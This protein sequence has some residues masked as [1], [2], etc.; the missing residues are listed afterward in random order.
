[1]LF[2][3]EHGGGAQVEFII[4]YDD[5]TAEGY[6]L[7]AIDEGKQASSGGI[8]GGVNAYFYFQKMESVR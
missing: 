2:Y 1:L 7:M 3:K 8:S 4:A 6:R 5:L